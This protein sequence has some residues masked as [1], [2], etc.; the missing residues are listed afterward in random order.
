MRRLVTVVVAAVLVAGCRGS[1]PE[2]GPAGPTAP[3]T[4]SGASTTTAAV[5][6]SGDVLLVWVP[7]GL[8][9]GSAEQLGALD[10]VLATTVVRAD[11]VG[12]ISDG[13]PAGFTVPV[14]AFSFDCATWPEFV[15]SDAEAAVCGVGSGGVVLGAKSAGLRSIGPGDV[16]RFAGGPAVRVVGV[17]EDE[18][19]GWAE[20]VVPSADSAAAGVR[21]PRYALVRHRGERDEVERRIRDAFPDVRMRVR[22]PG[23][24]PWFRHADDVLPPSLL[25]AELGEFATRVRPGGRLELDP[26]WREEHLVTVTLP[27][28]GQVTCHRAVVDALRGALT[29]IADRGLV[30]EVDRA[31]SGCWNARVIAGT[32]QPSRHSWGAALDIVPAPSD[33]A[34]VEVFDSW[35]FTWGGRWLTPDPVHFEYVRPPRSPSG[36]SPR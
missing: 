28:V 3:D 32:D 36:S 30:T 4:T 8:P 33:P 20:V 14:E 9:D 16:L 6:P 7:G 19:V 21:T 15:T 29:E 10:G 12:L 25:K 34:V 1:S 13:A 23:E 26:A 27:V 17:V 35:G 11:V 5:T 22:V 18:P 2:T 31:A 24:V